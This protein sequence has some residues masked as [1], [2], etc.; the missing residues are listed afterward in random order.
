MACPSSS[1]LRSLTLLG[2]LLVLCASS[3]FAQR[4]YEVS[5]FHAEILITP[6][7]STDVTENIT[8]RFAGGP[9]HGVY[10]DIPIQY[11]APNGLNYSYVLTVKSIEEDGVALKFESSTVRQYRRLKIYIPN[12]DNSAH[13][14]SIHYLIPNTVRFFPDHDEFFWNVTGNYWE[15]PI[16]QA[17]AHIVFP[18]D[19]KNLR[20]RVF[21]GVLGSHA[22]NAT[23]NVVGS[24][25]DVQTDASLAPREGLTIAIACDKGV[26]REPTRFDLFLLYLRSN[27]ALI[28][29]VLAFPLMFWWWWTRG[30]DP[31][32]R[33]IAAQYQPPERLSP[34]EIGT[35]VDNSVDMRDITATIVDLAVRGYL[36]IEEK[37]VSH[38]LGLTHSK[39]YLFHLK[40]AASD[41]TAL[42]PHEQQLL[43]GIFEQGVLDEV[44]SLSSL[45]NKFYT[46]ISPMKS[47][48]FAAL[49]GRSYY[50]RRPDSV[51]AGYVM[52]GVL[53]ALFLIWGGN[54]YA[55]N[56]GMA[57]L[58]FI[59]AGVLTGGIIAGF[60]WFMSARTVTGAR[61]LEQLLG[62]KDFL[63]HV[64]S[65]RFNRM[66]KTPEMFEKFLPF[67]MALGVEK[68]WSKAFQGIYTEPPQWYQ[69]GTFGP[70]FYP[71]AFVSNLNSLSSEAGGIMSSAPTSSGSS[72]FGGDGGGGSGG[73]GGGGGGGAF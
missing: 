17:S 32:L 15:V 33:P 47:Q 49:V 10:R 8:F 25:V 65:D 72:G 42:K 51:R 48:I 18:P 59:I 52:F 68:N 12:A 26:L 7:S 73:G 56:S 40:K 19:I 67:A 21:T 29:P 14:V 39:E 69:G 34:G 43:S 5:D 41:W 1:R 27:W 38:L 2:A 3:A 71:G 60:G 46:N 28:I 50:K 44:V 6:D 31:A 4:S 24:G 61:A 13:T 64:E 16:R 58:S 23:A 55:K 20:T 35:L 62:F 66:I 54:L 57:P 11:A 37:D 63:E 36:V 30:R 70:G 53:T 9:W 45:K 22:Q